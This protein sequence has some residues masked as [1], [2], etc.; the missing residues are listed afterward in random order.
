MSPSATNTTSADRD[1]GRPVLHDIRR[2]AER[3]QDAIYQYSSDAGAF[4]FYN[5]RFERFF[6]L[7]AVVT[8]SVTTPMVFDKIHPEDLKMVKKSLKNALE[9][10]SKK[11]E[12]ESAILGEIIKPV[13]KRFYRNLEI[14]FSQ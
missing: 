5:Q 6:D 8:D 7:P 13:N 14:Y 2:L 11:G 4:V 12:F 1:N 9:T 10:G 3:S